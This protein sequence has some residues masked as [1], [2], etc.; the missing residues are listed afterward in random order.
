M[1][2]PHTWPAGSEYPDTFII[3]DPHL[4]FYE[5]R[6]VVDDITLLVPAD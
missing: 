4:N 1:T 5:G 2:T 3:G 6:A